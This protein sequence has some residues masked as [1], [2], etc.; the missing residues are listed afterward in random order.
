MSPP[1]THKAPWPIPADI[2]W[3][4]YL[5]MLYDTDEDGRVYCNVCG[6]YIRDGWQA[7]HYADVHGR[8]RP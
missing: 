8:L 1:R 3:D 7:D 5:A 6:S 4:A 2:T